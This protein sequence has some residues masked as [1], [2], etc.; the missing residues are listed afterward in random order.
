MTSVRARLL[1]AAVRALRVK[2]VFDPDHLL[3]SI[4]ADRDK[5]PAEPNAR[6]LARFAVR[7]RESGDRRVVVVGP[8]DRPATRQVLYLHGGGWV[9]SITEPHWGLVGNLVDRL[10]CEITVPLYPLAPEHTARDVFAMLLPLYAETVAAADDLTLM[11]DSSGGNL[12]LSLAMQAR[13][14]GLPPPARLVLISP[15]LDVTFADPAMPALDRVDPILSHRGVPALGRLYAGD[16]DVRDPV[17]SPLLGDLGGLAPLA[18]FTGTRDLLNADAHRLRD[19]M[20]LCWHE[21][22]GMLHVWPLFPIPE[23]RAAIEQ[24]ADFVEAPHV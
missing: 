6:F 18:V 16:L 24:I 14:R 11:G 19:K 23:A 17:V 5:G 10:G 21:Y 3:G 8:R 1:S 12:A 2:R 20:P 7:E 4:A 22:P 13:D 15:G 9:L